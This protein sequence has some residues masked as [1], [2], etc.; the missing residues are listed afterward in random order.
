MRKFSDLE[1]AIRHSL[2]PG[3]ARWICASGARGGGF[4]CAGQRADRRHVERPP[5]PWKEYLM[6][7]DLVVKL[8]ASDEACCRFMQ[9]PGVSA[10]WLL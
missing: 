5:A 8:V 4:R 3:W 10:R 7:H 6:L 1:N 2:E 9:I